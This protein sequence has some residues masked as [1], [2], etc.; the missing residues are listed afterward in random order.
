MFRFAFGNLCGLLEVQFALLAVASKETEHLV[1]MRRKIGQ[2]F[3]DRHDQRRKFLEVLVMG[4]P[5]LCLLPQVFNGIVIRRIRRQ[6]MG[7]DPVA[8]G[9]EK[10]FGCLAGVIPC[11]IMDQKQVLAGLSHDHVQKRLVTF[12][13][14]PPFDALIEQTA[15]EILNGPIHLVAFPF[16]TGGDLGLLATPRPGVRG[17]PKTKV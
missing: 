13:V 16:A 1:C 4:S 2:R 12:G 9:R 15:G 14:E 5:L 6:R 7:R 10:L 11:P 8:M 3:L 17:C